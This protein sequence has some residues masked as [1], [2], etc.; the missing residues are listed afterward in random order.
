MSFK[1]IT[2]VV[3]YKE[4]KKETLKTLNSI[5]LDNVSS[6]NYDVLII[7]DGSKDRGDKD[8]LSFI[9][10][11]KL[12][13]FK[14]IALSEYIGISQVFKFL[15][16]TKQIK[17]KYISFLFEGDIL[18]NDTIKYFVENL[19][20]L[21][22]DMYVSKCLVYKPYVK[23]N[24]RTR[25][26]KHYVKKIHYN[27]ILFREGTID[28][29][30][31]KSTAP[32]FFGRI[33]KVS[34]IQNIHSYEERILYQDLYFYQ[35]MIEACDSFYHFNFNSGD[36][37]LRSWLAPEMDRERIVLLCRTIDSLVSDDPVL[38][39]MLVQILSMAIKKTRKNNIQHYEIDNI[40]KLLNFKFKKI[41]GFNICKFGVQMAIKELMHTKKMIQKR[42]QQ[43]KEMSFIS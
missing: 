31:V 20:S 38:N 28:K 25:Q 10:E 22:K 26:T 2:F 19:Y 34:K 16:R 3:Y 39:G 24:Q 11:N 27:P 8:I 36:T 12:F 29:D 15:M 37:I 35:K 42:R 6:V 23:I 1:K 13:N 14:Y 41:V 17:S 7:N 9:D 43:E 33:F 18:K 32:I 40:E 4:N 30:T 21:N 5:L